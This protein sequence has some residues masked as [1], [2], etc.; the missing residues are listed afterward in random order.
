SSPPSGLRDACPADVDL[1][2]L[3]ALAKDPED[4][5]Q[6]AE[7][8]NA[9]LARIQRGLAVSS[10]TTDAPTAVPAGPGISGVPTIIPPRPTQVAPPQP[11]PP[12]TPAGYYG[13]EGP[14][15]RSR[16]IWPGVLVLL[17][18]IGGGCAGG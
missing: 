10:E 11:P 13:Y 9:D 7:E 1:V 12:T 5:Y 3:R 15:R 16:S 4:R 14:P 2:V 6:T 18:V 17:L 8:M